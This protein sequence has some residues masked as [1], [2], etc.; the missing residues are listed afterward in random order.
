LRTQPAYWGPRQYQIR[1]PKFEIRNSLAVCDLDLDMLTCLIVAS[2]QLS[3]PQPMDQIEAFILAGGASSRMG[4]DKAELLI[5]NQSF[6]QRIADILFAVIKSVTVVGRSNTDP[7]LKTALDVYPGWGALGGL[8]AALQ[9][10]TSSWA[11]VIACDLPFVTSELVSRLADERSQYEAV[12][13]IQP[14]G[15]PQPLCAL[16]SVQPCLSVAAKLIEQGKRRPLDLLERV[17]TRWVPFRELTE[18]AR[19][20]KFFVNINTPEDYYEAIRIE[21]NANHHRQP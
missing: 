17:N 11:F 1:S 19:S 2:P 18:L 13:C 20:E 21:A 7:R 14:D 8:H 16:Y 15:R 3:T 5:E 9:S 6:I 4:K 12:V 10:C